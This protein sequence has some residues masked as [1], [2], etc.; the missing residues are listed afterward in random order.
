MESRAEKRIGAVPENSEK[1]S[2]KK[3]S[4]LKS[5][6]VKLRK[7]L[8]SQKE[9]TEGSAGEKMISKKKIKE[10]LTKN[11]VSQKENPKGINRSLR[12]GSRISAPHDYSD[13]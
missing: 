2:L 5:R 8:T 9:K 4:E 3:K 12:E 10:A 11:V 6:K 7:R 13:L 1:N